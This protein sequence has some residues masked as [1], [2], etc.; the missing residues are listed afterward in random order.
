MSRAA[1]GAALVAVAALLAL[2]TGC[3]VTATQ[4]ASTIPGAAPSTTLA[5]TT[6]STT[7]TIAT[8]TTALPPSKAVDGDPLAG[9]LSDQPID[10]LVVELDESRSPDT[11]VATNR[12]AMPIELALG[13]E[14][15][16]GVRTEPAFPAHV[17]VPPLATVDAAK[18][19]PTNPSSGWSYTY[20]TNYELGDPSAVPSPVTYLRPLLADGD[21]APIGQGPGG[22]FSHTDALNRW[23]YDFTMPTGTPVVAARAGTVATIEQG[24]TQA[25][26][27]EEFG[28]KGNSVRVLHDDGTY[29]IYLHLDPRSARVRIGDHVEAGQLLALSGNTGWSKGPHLHLAVLANRNHSDESVH[30]DLQRI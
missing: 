20:T 8:T 14:E 6:S 5:T 23:A 15:S 7:T 18:I 27:T 21:R 22:E 24:F 29:A 1:R 26:D 30:F 13:F 3:G 2:A 11:L 9:N 4:A 25:G 19:Y 10:W 12:S 28:L 16:T 17:M